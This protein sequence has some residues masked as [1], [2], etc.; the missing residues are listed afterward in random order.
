MLK[1]T[2]SPKE[3][4]GTNPGAIYGTVFKQVTDGRP[5]IIT[6]CSDK[7][8]TSAIIFALKSQESMKDDFAVAYN[9]IK[10][11]LKY[12]PVARENSGLIYICIHPD[13]FLIGTT[14]LNMLDYKYSVIED[15]TE[16]MDFRKK[17]EDIF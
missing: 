7:V 17:I 12:V 14:V 13:D 6:S 4:D 9:K 10:R 11:T 16:Y 3:N 5:A 2:L 15:Y 1:F 8:A